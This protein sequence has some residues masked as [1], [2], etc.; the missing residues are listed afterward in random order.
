MK[1]RPIAALDVEVRRGQTVYPEPFARV[2]AGRTK[3]KLGDV[4]GLSNFG[5][6]LTHLEPGAA[7]A[8]FHSHALQDEFVFV[9]EGNPTIAFG[10][11]EYRLS[12]G[13]CM[14]FKAGTGIGHQVINRTAEVVAYLE[15]G[16]RTQGERVEYPKDDIAAQAGPD[17]GWLMTRKDGT[18]F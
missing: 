14:G 17:G 18:P 4:F 11:R 6:N 16:D 12:P 5:V 3:R 9:L 1:D 7:S 15:I 10:D 13:D 2:V 8:L